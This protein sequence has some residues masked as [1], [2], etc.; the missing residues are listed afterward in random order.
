[1]IAVR[2]M[3]FVGK[4]VR[5]P[6]EQPTK[7]MI[8]ACCSNT[9][10]DGRPRYHNKD[11]MVKNLKLLLQ[12]VP[13]VVIGDKGSLKDWINE[14]SHEKYWCKLT[15]CLLNKDA[16]IPK[17]PAEWPRQRR[18]PRNHDGAGQQPFQDSPPRRRRNERESNPPPSPPRRSRVPPP[19]RPA[20]NERERDYIPENVGRTLYGSF[21]I[22]GLGLGATE[23]EVKLKYRALSRIYHP[24]KHDSS[25]TGKTDEEASD[26]FKMINNAQSY[27][28]EVL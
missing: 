15:A 23:T 13:G 24:D 20:N 9:R 3:D 11:S 8:T 1:M 19:R 18:S 7:R 4:V 17:R 21:K 6:R 22:L 16:E 27:L 5:G 26:F 10:L 14:A 25:K 28:R 2:Q 12:A